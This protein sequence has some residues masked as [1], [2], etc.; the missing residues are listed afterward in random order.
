MIHEGQEQKTCRNYNINFVN[1]EFVI[2]FCQIALDLF[3]K[4]YNIYTT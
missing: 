2:E 1:Q 4:R 3:R